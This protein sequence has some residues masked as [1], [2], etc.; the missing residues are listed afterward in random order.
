L[1][2]NAALRNA[3]RYDELLSPDCRA[4]NRESRTL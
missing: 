3:L 2:E 4:T 1:L